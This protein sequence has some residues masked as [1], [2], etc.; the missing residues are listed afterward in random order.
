MEFP[1]QS[2]GMTVDELKRSIN[3]S[4][5]QKKYAPEMEKFSES[6]K[7]LEIQI[8][9]TSKKLRKIGVQ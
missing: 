8:I 6:T 7:R 5:E 2:K 4:R 9:T 3:N 1:A